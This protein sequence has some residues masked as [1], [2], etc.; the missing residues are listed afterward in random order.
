MLT[1]K[2][3]WVM[4]AS[5]I[6]VIGSVMAGEIKFTAAI[7]PLAGI[8]MAWLTAQGITDAGKTAAQI[9]SQPGPT[10]VQ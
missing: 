5:V 10:K 3:F 6:G 2:K 4:L 1:S 7:V 9:N 8:I